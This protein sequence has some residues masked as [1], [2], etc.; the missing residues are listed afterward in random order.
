MASQWND[1]LFFSCEEVTSFL[2]VGG[3]NW[4]DECPR[5][6][7]AVVVLISLVSVKL[8]F[9]PV[10]VAV[11]D[12]GC[13][14]LPV[15]MMLSDVYSFYRKAWAMLPLFGLSSPGISRCS[16]GFASLFWANDSGDIS[17]V[18]RHM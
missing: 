8:A 4:V 16:A 6:G 10:G 3:L 2:S 12:F 17:V 7:L 11:G 5:C 15:S 1:L 18:R 14:S 9:L 13:I